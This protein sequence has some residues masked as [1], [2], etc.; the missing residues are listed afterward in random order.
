[1]DDVLTG[2][3]CGPTPSPRITPPSTDAT[4]GPG[5]VSSGAGLLLVLGALSLVAGGTLAL[6]ARRWR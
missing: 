3:V 5:R 2:T 1:M 4:A 6:T